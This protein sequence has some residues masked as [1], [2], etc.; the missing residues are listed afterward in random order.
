MGATVADSDRDVRWMTYAEAAA[1]LG[2]N[3]ESVAK[4]MRRRGWATRLG[5]DGKPRVAVPVSVLPTVL[6][7]VPVTVPDSPLD[8]VPSAA[9]INPPLSPEV[10]GLVLALA[11]QLQTATEQSGRLDAALL[12]AVRQAAV[13][14]GE[15]R[16]LRNSLAAAEARANR[17]EAELLRL[18]L[19]PWWKRWMGRP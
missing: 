9:V 19:W 13:A 5:N 2:V 18:A 3:P 17:L 1:A 4:R 10:A 16:A 8:A 14:E 11:A 15:A 6:Q 12:D 7:H